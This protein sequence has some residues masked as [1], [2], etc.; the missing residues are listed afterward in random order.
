MRKREPSDLEL[1]AAVLIG[2]LHQLD[3]T[4]V[5]GLVVSTVYTLDYGFE[6]AI[7]DNPVRCSA[8]PVERYGEDRTA[9]QQG[10]DLWVAWARDRRH[11]AVTKLGY[12]SL[13]QAQVVLLTRQMPE[14]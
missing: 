2:P 8:Y 3:R 7:V 12:G 1:M 11:L 5:E 4:Y 13:S 6:T 14:E 10:H 9:A